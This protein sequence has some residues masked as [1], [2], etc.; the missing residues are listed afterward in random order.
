M[1]YQTLVMAKTFLC[2]QMLGKLAKWLRA[3][4]YDTALAEPEARDQE[5]LAQA[6]R[7]KRC[8]MTRDRHFLELDKGST[9]VFFLKGN[10]L[11]EWVQEATALCS[12]DWLYRP[13]TRCLECNSV[14]RSVARDVVDVP[15]KVSQTMDVFLICPFC[16]KTYWEGS[17]AE[18]MRMQL[19]A[20][21]EGNFTSK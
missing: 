20:W 5:I 21:K 1:L 15:P 3:A 2:D 6:L 14:L 12:I 8:L 10:S 11:Q 16:K 13:L 19:K 9:Q 17:H 7:E 18:R 4:G